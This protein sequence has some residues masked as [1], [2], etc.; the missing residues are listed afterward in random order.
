MDLTEIL[1]EE[2]NWISILQ[3]KNILPI[4]LGGNLAVNAVL[5]RLR[6]YLAVLISSRNYLKCI[7]VVALWLNLDIVRVSQQ[8]KSK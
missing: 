6:T 5:F 4:G 1:P 2:N 7:P 8:A 3:Y